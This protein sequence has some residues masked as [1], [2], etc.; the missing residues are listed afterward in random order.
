[1][2]RRRRS[3]IGS[4]QHQLGPAVDGFD[5]TDFRRLWVQC[6][7]FHAQE[8]Q[9]LLAELFDADEGDNKSKMNG[10]MASLF[11]HPDGLRG[12]MMATADAHGE[13]GTSVRVVSLKSNFLTPTS[14]CL[15]PTS[16][17]VRPGTQ[18]GAGLL[19]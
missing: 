13:Y 4:T 18:R 16:G 14:R 11:L 6:S 10:R 5:L 1:M 12:A 3:Q 2:L 7:G 9:N 15:P 19:H 8:P 17:G